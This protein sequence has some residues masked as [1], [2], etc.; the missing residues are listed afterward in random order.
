[1]NELRPRSGKDVHG[2]TDEA[3]RGLGFPE[4]VSESH[5]EP[6]RPAAAPKP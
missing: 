2:T 3:D 1:M 4:R 5:E 6:F